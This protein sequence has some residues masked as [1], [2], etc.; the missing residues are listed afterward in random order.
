MLA[1]AKL[2]AAG[3]HAFVNAGMNKRIEDEQVAPPRQRRQHSEIGEVATGEEDRAL[4]AE[5]Y[6]GL[7]LEV[8][9]LGAIAAQ[10]PR[11][12]G[13]DRRAGLECS[14][15][16]LSHPRRRRKRKIIVG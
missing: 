8:L 1:E 7:G 13:A 14:G 11:A 4:R 2:G 3:P 9:V 6:C 15:K 12:A 10:K 5:I 16:R